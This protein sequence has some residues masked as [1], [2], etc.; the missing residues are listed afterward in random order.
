[1]TSFRPTLVRATVLAL[2][3]A[4]PM[5]WA[6]DVW[7]LTGNDD[8]ATTENQLTP[9][10]WQVHDMESTGG[11]ADQDWFLV[12]QT[13]YSSYE[14]VVDGMTA[15]L[16]AVPVTVPGTELG[17][18][19]VYGGGLTVPSN[20]LGAP[21]AARALYFRNETG[22]AIDGDKIRVSNPACATSCSAAEQ[23]RIQLND[24]TY[25]VPRYNNSATQI[26]ILIVQ[27]TTARVVY[28]NAHFFDVN[29][30]LVAT[31]AQNLPPLGTQ[32]LNTSTV[33]NVAGTSGSIIVNNDGRYGALSGKVVSLE[34]ATG[35]TFDTAMVPRPQ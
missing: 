18:H 29:G 30:T 13:P 8:G 17:V 21:G 32:V 25:S 5:I 9:G 12:N 2:L 11:V 31:H 22:A 6:Q 24:T 27:N 1:M 7:D 4:S 3:V 10:T 16:G 19:L 34:P 28:F 20:T 26:S 23:Y 35:F 15:G 14:V 33:P